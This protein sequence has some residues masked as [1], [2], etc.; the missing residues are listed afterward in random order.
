[1][2]QMKSSLIPVLGIIFLLAF[3]GQQ[4]RN[5]SAVANNLPPELMQRWFHSYE[6]DTQTEKVYRPAEFEF[7]LSRGRTGFGFFPDG[8]FEQ[9]DIAPTDGVEKSEG[10]W[11]PVSDKEIRIRLKQ[12]REGRPADY[13][14][15]MKSVS[16]DKLILIP[17]TEE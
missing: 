15:Q 12:V 14:M 16:K 7:P 3:S 17:K 5:K 13:V 1:M 4:C 2:I 8:R 6:E 11:T 9:Y 10:T